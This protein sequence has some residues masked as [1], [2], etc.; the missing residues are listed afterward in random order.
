MSS[1][2]TVAGREVDYVAA[3]SLM[4]DE[5]R[6][7]LHSSLPRTVNDPAEPAR[8]CTDQEFADAYAAAHEAK[9]GKEFV[10]A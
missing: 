5:I 9:F 2:V 4:D 6:E 1:K 8:F 10:V 7:A 3:V